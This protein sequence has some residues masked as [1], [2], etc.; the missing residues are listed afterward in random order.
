[1]REWK[2][3]VNLGVNHKG[4]LV[5]AESKFLIQAPPP[6][7]GW[8]I[9]TNQFLPEIVAEWGQANGELAAQ[10]AITYKEGDEDSWTYIV[11]DNRVDPVP[12]PYE[13]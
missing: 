12:S 2:D 6:Y 11:T 7:Q 3:G 4:Q 1:M 10:N 5:V 13:P 8:S 9:G